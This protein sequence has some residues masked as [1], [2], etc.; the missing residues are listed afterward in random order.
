MY[1]PLSFTQ[2]DEV[3][4]FAKSKGKPLVADIPDK[5]IGGFNP[6]G[7]SKSTTLEEFGRNLELGT[8]LVKVPDDTF[9]VFKPA[10]P[11]QSRLDRLDRV[12]LT[13]LM[14]AT[15][16]KGVPSLD[17]MC[18]Y[19]NAAPNPMSGGVGQMYV[20]LFV[21]GAMSTGMDGMTSWDM[22]RLYGQLGPESRSTLANGGKLALRSL[23][24]SEHAL[25][26]RM[27]YGSE[28]QLSVEDPNKKEP[29]VPSWMQMAGLAGGGDYKSE[30]TEVVPSGLPADGYIELKDTVEPFVAPVP[31][32]ESSTMAMLGVLGPQE[33]GMF[34]MLRSSPGMEQ[35]TAM[36]PKFD[37]LHVGERT[38]LNFTFHLAPLVSL[39]QTLKD[40]RIGKDG[41]LY[42]EDNLPA[43]MQKRIAEETELLKKSPFGAL[44]SFMGQGQGIHP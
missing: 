27:T 40:H 35:V 13:A 2:T 22:L 7:N 17:D 43:D 30:P 28:T 10:A 15:A 31:D 23:S 34:K 18:A 5:A 37:H 20:M 16:Q 29:E 1:D 9:V 3:L 14:Q 8:T 4:F 11:A 36:F 24:P 42:S 12:A 19:A 39:K 33:L 32:G 26:E 25:V 38:L 6:Y 44:G 21:P 41:T